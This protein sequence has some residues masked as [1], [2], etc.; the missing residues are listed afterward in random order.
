M[1]ESKFMFFSV[2][3]GALP[4]AHQPALH[5]P[6]PLFSILLSYRCNLTENVLKA[7]DCMN[8]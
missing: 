1:F 5:N 6:C 8:T 4:G 2:V 7:C 3:K